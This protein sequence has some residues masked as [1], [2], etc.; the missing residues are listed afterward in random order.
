MQ[1][2]VSI[3]FTDP[4]D[5][6][7]LARAAEDNGFA[8]ITLPDHLIY[9]R[10]LSVPYPYTPD[11]VPRFTPEDPFP[12]PWLGAVAMAAV[13]GRLWF[14]TS[15]YVLPARNPFHV[16]KQLASAA[17]LSGGRMALGVGV[18]WMPEE[19]AAAGQ[20][21]TGRGRRTDEMLEVMRKLWTGQWVEHHGEFYDFAPLQMRPAPR[22]PIPVY[23]GGFSEPAMRR[24][25]RHDGWIAD[26]HTLAEL[27]ALIG[28]M[29]AYREEVGRAQEPFRILSF[30]CMDAWDANGFRAM[31]DIGV[32]VVSTMPWV[33]YGVDLQ[34]PVAAKID[35][36]RRFADEVIAKL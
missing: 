27:E 2:G 12:D 7:A 15:V 26:L 35:G 16:A 34:A 33:F 8:A 5:Y 31:R 13:T 3:A 24:A 20:A 19:F 23:I 28:R 11:G 18:G 25:A 4:D 10:E 32:D 30:G 14:Y 17:R 1:F 22:E 21:F 36:M 9:P 6:A 29:R